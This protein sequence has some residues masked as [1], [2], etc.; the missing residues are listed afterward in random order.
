MRRIVF[1][2]KGGVGKTTIAC[3]MAI[4][5]ARSGKK[6]LQIGCDPKHDSAYKHTE[7]SKITT[8]MDEFIRLRN[9][10]S[11]G[12]LRN[13]IVK[14]RTGVYCMEVGGP[15]PG[16]GC[17]G[18]AVSLVLNF[19]KEDKK[20]FESF[21]VVIFDI[22]GDVVCGGFASP[23]QTREMTDVY[24]VVSGE[25]MSIYAANNIAKGIKN[26]STSSGAKL[27]GLIANLKNTI[28]ESEIISSFA[29]RLGTGVTGTIPFNNQVFIAEIQGKTSIE[30]F[31]DSE[32][33]E[34]YKN[35]YEKIS[36]ACDRDRVI[37]SPLGDDVLRKFFLKYAKRAIN[38]T[39]SG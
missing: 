37:P 16:K 19:L 20:F 18:R 15:I 13:L 14:G 8:V 9:N 38:E 28:C 23:L 31:P 36:S 32:M 29:S 4:L 7:D 39:E 26:L 2:G 10:L 1:L 25:F 17:A 3:N 6:V 34:P 21:D 22:L 35:L 27:S 11:P 24:V 33:S 5:F 30:M 12:D